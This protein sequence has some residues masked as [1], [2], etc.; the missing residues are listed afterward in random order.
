MRKKMTQMFPVIN[1]IDDVREAIRGRDEFHLLQRD[2]YWVANYF[3]NFADSFPSPNTSDLDLNRQFMLRRECRG[4]IFDGD[5]KVIRRPY[6]KFFNY[7]EKP[8]TSLPEFKIEL[9]HHKLE[10]LDGSMIAPF[11]SNNTLRF[12]TKMGVTDVSLP[13]DQWVKNH[14]QY[15]EWCHYMIK[16]NYTPIF[17]WCSRKQRIV[18]DYP[19]DRLVLTAVRNM[20]T[21][22]YLSY[23]QMKEAEDHGIEV[24]RAWDEGIRDLNKFLEEARLLTDMEGFVIRFE[25]GHMCKVKAD[26]YLQL[27]RTKDLL[28]YEK[29][30]LDLIMS[31]KIDDAKGFMDPITLDIVNR[32][33]TCLHHEIS[34]TALRLKKIVS[35]AR[36]SFESKK[37]FAVQVVGKHPVNNER[38]ILF[39]IWDRGEEMAL[40][41]VMKYISKYTSTQT[42]VD[43]VRNLFNGLRWDSF[44]HQTN[45]E[46]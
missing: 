25:T 39:N 17:E 28:N 18:I 37:D 45:L 33:E 40:E 44:Y 2:D 27:H 13:V 41:E 22:E 9:P 16:N 29:D 30:V 20:T 6:H 21:G 38:T 32:Y 10:K 42:R 4:I 26:H 24:V 7:G 43:S 36:R 8:E 11:I 35:D 5:G 34:Q 1:S 12:G 19:V 23:N 46:E 31:E 15:L 3:V 14:L